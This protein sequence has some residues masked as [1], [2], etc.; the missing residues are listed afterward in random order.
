[1]AG[2]YEVCEAV[3]SAGDDSKNWNGAGVQTI[4]MLPSLIQSIWDTTKTKV[5][6]DDPIDKVESHFKVLKS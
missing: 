2:H 1:M 3:I 5:Q 6:P 4:L